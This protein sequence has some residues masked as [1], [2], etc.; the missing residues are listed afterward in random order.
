MNTKV[1]FHEGDL[2]LLYVPTLSNAQNRIIQKKFEIYEGPC[3]ISKVL[4]NGSYVLFKD[5]NSEIVKG[6]Y[7]HS[8][9]K[10]FIQREGVK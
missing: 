6:T 10:P 9:L 3:E 1:I 5:D 4:S 2:V 8:Q 7:H